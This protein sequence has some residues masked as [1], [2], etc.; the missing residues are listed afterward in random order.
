MAHYERLANGKY[1]YTTTVQVISPTEFT[2]KNH[3]YF[4]GTVKI[5]YYS[6]STWRQYY[7]IP[8]IMQ[9]PG[10]VLNNSICS[11]G[12][13]I[14]TKQSP[15]NA[16]NFY[17][18]SQVIDGNTYYGILCNTDRF[19][20]ITFKWKS[21]TGSDDRM[22]RVDKTKFEITYIPNG[23]TSIQTK[24]ITASTSNASAYS[25]SE[26]YTNIYIGLGMS[27]G[28]IILNIKATPVE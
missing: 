7:Y 27:V 24:T 15:L 25:S 9:Y 17:Y 26:T 11:S 2:D 21:S 14:V 20:V 1:A 4:S 19:I 22:W 23:T 6:N 3:P 16:S 10:G 18:T 8:Q 28:D 12:A 5:S 13:N